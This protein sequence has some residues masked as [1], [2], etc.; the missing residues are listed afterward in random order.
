MGGTGKTPMVLWLAD[1]L[2]RRELRVAIVSRGYKSQSGQPND[3]ALELAQRLPDVPHI[4]DG[5]RVKAA[6]V[7]VDQHGSQ[8]IVLDDGFQHRR[9]AR[10]L[11]L[12]LIDALEPF[13]FEHVF[14]RGMLREPLASLARAD[15]VALSRAD[16]IDG[17]SRQA[18]RHRVEKMAPHAGW[19]E[20]VHAPAAFVSS[21]GQQAELDALAGQPVAAFCGI[22]NP[23]GFRHTLKACNLDVQAFHEFPDHHHYGV[24]ERAWLS[25]WVGSLPNIAAVV[26]THKDLV[27]IAASRIGTH[28]LW[29]ITIGLEVRA[30]RDELEH[31]LQAVLPP[32]SG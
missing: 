3:E 14:P 21:D 11:D 8:M 7:A 13:G 27:K 10:D 23:A 16:A 30:G 4:Q 25:D 22:G 2:R 19:L 12:V 28:A 26:C 9:I 6:Q 32:H 18:I 29:A 17:P 1:W 24:A 15:L 20:L 5:D 31:R